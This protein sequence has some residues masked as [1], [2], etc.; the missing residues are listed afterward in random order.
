MLYKFEVKYTE[1][2]SNCVTFAA[3][4]VRQPIKLFQF[5]QKLYKTLGIGSNQQNGKVSFNSRNS[6]ALFCFIQLFIS[7]AAFFVF[8]A[9]S[10]QEYY[11]AFFMALTQFYLALDLLALM[12]QIPN[13]LNLITDYEQFI[14]KSE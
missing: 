8:K 3:N 7:T 9:K 6:L 5:I 12:W 14:E 10:T 4:M 11:A 2:T 13:V 1:E